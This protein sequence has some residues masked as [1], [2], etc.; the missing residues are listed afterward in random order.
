VYDGHAERWG[1]EGEAFD[2]LLEIRG[3][4]ATFAPIGTSFAYQAGQSLGVVA[5]YPASKR[6]EGY[7]VLVANLEQ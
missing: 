1:L 6:S 4:P 5:L 2:Q 3:Q 7:L